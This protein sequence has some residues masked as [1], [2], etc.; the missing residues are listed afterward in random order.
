MSPIPIPVT[1][2]QA[3]LGPPFLQTGNVPANWQW[4]AVIRHPKG[5]RTPAS[6]S[7]HPCCV[8]QVLGFEIDAVNSVQFSN[9]TGEAQLEVAVSQTLLLF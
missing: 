5:C 2:T 6:L 9:H 1:S 8:F 4:Q 3:G 7:C